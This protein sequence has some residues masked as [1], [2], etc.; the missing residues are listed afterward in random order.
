MVTWQEFEKNVKEL[1][2]YIWSCNAVNE[3]VN[4]VKFDCVLKPKDNYWILVEITEDESLT[5]VRTDISKLAT[6]RPFLFSQNIYAECFIVM[7]NEPTETMQTTGSGLFISVLSYSS[8]SK[9]FIDYSSYVFARNKKVFGSSVNPLSG[10]P[11]SNNYTPVFYQ[12]L[13][14]KKDVSLKDIARCISD[15]KRMILLGNYGTGKSRCIRELFFTLSYKAAGKILYP[16]AINL[17]E[18]WGQQ[19]ADELIRRHLGSLGLSN[20]ADSLIKIIDS[21]RFIFLLDGF[22]E[23]GSQVWSDDTYKLKQI[24]SSSLS[25]IHDLISSTKSPIIITGREHYFSS[26]KEMFQLLGL[27]NSE[28]ELFKCKD[29]FTE[30]EMENYLQSISLA[31]DLPIWLPKRPLICQII[32]TIRKEELDKIFIDSYSAVEFW[33]TLI[34][35]ICEREARISP[36]L[37]SETI[38]NT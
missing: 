36:K 5:K 7:R 3:T 33:N 22:D 19:R 10:E 11:D 37:Q 8:F 21:D 32:N 18:H 13:R 16:I 27:K 24:R 25:A 31:V 9:R 23:I 14:T 15:G 1:S 4:G 34:K 6:A 35:N 2:S 20:L 28:T 12:N 29:E 38:Y 30:S 17:K 26:D